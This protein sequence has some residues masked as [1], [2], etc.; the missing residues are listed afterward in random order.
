MLR[1]LIYAIAVA[2]LTAGVLY[3]LGAFLLVLK[4][5]PLAVTFG[6]LLKDYCGLIGLLAGIAYFV[7]GFP[8]TPARR[9]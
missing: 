3:L 2:I 5:L 8:G 1:R 4:D 9:V 7:F 6:T